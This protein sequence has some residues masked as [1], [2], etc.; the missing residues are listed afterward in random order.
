MKLDGMTAQNADPI[1]LGLGV[2]REVKLRRQRLPKDS[3]VTRPAFHD[4]NWEFRIW[5]HDDSDEWTANITTRGE[6]FIGPADL[7]TILD[8]ILTRHNVKVT[9]EDPDAGG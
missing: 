2:I 3:K 4:E 6:D 8:G 9:L 5:R 1:D 7:Q